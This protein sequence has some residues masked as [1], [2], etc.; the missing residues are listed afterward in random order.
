MATQPLSQRDLLD[1]LVGLPGWELK[2]GKIT[3]EFVFSD[4]N[5]AWGWMSRVALDAEKLNHHPEW[6][7]VYRTVHIHLQTHDVGGVTDLDIELARRMN[8]HAE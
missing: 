4:F 5:E 7:N 2:A 1:K 8:A 3:K 6:S